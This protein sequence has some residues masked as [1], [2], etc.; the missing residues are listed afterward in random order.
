[1]STFED[2]LKA[3]QTKT[4]K[5]MA[6]IVESVIV[7][8]MHSVTSLS[9]WGDWPE[10][11]FYWQARRPVDPELAAAMGIEPYAPGLFRGNW[12]YGR[13][14]PPAAVEYDTID[15][16]AGAS[17]AR[18]LAGMGAI[19]VEWA[20]AKHYI[21]NNLPYA[22]KMESGKDLVGHNLALGHMLEITGQN[23]NNIVLGAVH[24]SLGR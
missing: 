2:Q 7:Q 23:F 19:T 11:S 22:R 1:M 24:A 10:W 12:D 3:F 8:S 6:K 21:V 15:P 18:I 20:A 17:H 16:S 14:I 9:P 4:N 13:N 5:T